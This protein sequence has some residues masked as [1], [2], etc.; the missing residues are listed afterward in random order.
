MVLFQGVCGGRSSPQVKASSITAA[1]GAQRALSRSS[2]DRSA[3]WIAQLVT[4]HAVRPLRLPGNAFRVR[5]EQDLVGIEAMP[6]CRL[7]GAVDPVT[8]DLVR[9]DVGQIAVPNQIGALGHGNAAGFLVGVRRVEQ[10]Q[11]H[12][13]GVFRVQG[14]VH[15]AAVP[16]RPQGIGAAGPHSRFSWHPS[17]DILP[18]S[19]MCQ[20]TSLLPCLHPHAT[21]RRKGSLPGEPPGSSRRIPGNGRSCPR[22]CCAAPLRFGPGFRWCCPAGSRPGPARRLRRRGPPCP[23]MALASMPQPLSAV[24]ADWVT[25]PCSLAQSASKARR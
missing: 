14:E 4:P 5:I 1:S 12:L 7:V 6:L 11:L 15:A 9:Q 19:T 3:C 2:N 18:A 21:R 10:A 20:A 17:G 8:V 16:G 13:R 25:F 23:A 22:R 24:S